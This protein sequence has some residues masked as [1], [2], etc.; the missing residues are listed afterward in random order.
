MEERVSKV[1]ITGRGAVSPL[2]TGV[3]ALLEGLASNTV[4]IE[5]APWV[6][7]HDDMFAWWAPVKDFDPGRWVDAKVEDGTDLFAQYALASAVQSVQEAGLR[8]LDPRRTAVVHGTSMGGTRALLK[9]QHRLERSGPHAID[10]KT[11]IK[12]WPNMAAAQIAMR[13]GLHG[14]QLTICTACASSID[15]IGVA[16]QMIADGRADVALAGGTEGGLALPDGT[17]DGEFVP[18]MYFG[19]TAYG[20]TTGERDPR[21]ASLPFDRDRSGIVSG[22]GSAMLVLESEEHARERGATVLGEVA[23]YASLADGYHP[24]SPEPSGRWEAEVMR[25]AL[26][27]AGLAPDRVDAVIAHGTATPK[28]DTAEIRA[29]IDVFGDHRHELQVTSL[30]GHFGHTGAASGAM[31]V[32]TATDVMNG[33]ALPNTAGT[34]NVDPEADFPVVT[35]KPLALEA[36][37]MQI[38]AFGFGGQNSSLVVRSAVRR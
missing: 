14:P 29:I 19:Q 31:S 28:G 25:E 11:M 17:L 24:S 32:I 8:D 2:G 15:A 1:V 18:A 3:P 10:R 30:K 27:D 12:I 36:S 26:A 33:G 20:M 9:A 35:G 23:G 37:V 7:G 6:E 21:R 4:A 5:E 22:E 34:V 16:A 38:N 13:W